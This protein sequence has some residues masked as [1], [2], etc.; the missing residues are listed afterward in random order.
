MRATEEIEDLRLK[1][2]DW[3]ERQRGSVLEAFAEL[4]DEIEVVEKDVSYEDLDRV[5]K[6]IKALD[7]AVT[8]WKGFA[9]FAEGVDL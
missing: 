3:E 1:A 2:E 5:H 9:D 8:E 4:H 7:E 6:K